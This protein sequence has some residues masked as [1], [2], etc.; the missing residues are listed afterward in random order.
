MAANLNKK[1]ETTKHF[2]IFFQKKFI[3]LF[4]PLFRYGILMN[5]LNDLYQICRIND[6]VSIDISH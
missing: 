4:F 5:F 1:L 6:F 2:G 3:F